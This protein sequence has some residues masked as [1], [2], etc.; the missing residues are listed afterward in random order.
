M[1]PRARSARKC[2]T[3]RSSSEWKEMTPMRPPGRSAAQASGSARS[4]CSSSSLTAIRSAWKLRLAGWPPANRAR[5]RNGRLDRRPPAPGW[6][7]SAPRARRR[8][9]A[10]A[11]APRVAL[12]A[13]LAQ[14]AGQP[15]LVP[16]VDDLGARSALVGVHAH[17]QR[18]V[19]AVGEAALA[20]IDL[21]RG[22][23]E[24]ERTRGRRARPPRSAGPARRRT[25]PRMKRVAHGTSAASSAKRS[26]ATGSR[27]M[28]ISVP[29]G[30]MRPAI[31]RA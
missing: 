23:A 15:A 13:V 1:Q 20:R 25:S 21:K 22:D 17:V 24:V 14:D 12:L 3:R 29:D 7:R 4:S 2:L 6:S 11:I 16:L 31:R 19:V 10:R 18:R 30:P 26:S 9:M 8:T 5:R 28:P 27:S